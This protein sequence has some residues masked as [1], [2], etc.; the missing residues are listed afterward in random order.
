MKKK[1]EML[2]SDIWSAK[3]AYWILVLKVAIMFVFTIDGDRYYIWQ[4]VGLEQN[5]LKKNSNQATD[6]QTIVEFHCRL[7]DLNAVKPKM[8]LLR[9]SYIFRNFK[10]SIICHWQAYHFSFQLKSQKFH[11]LPHHSRVCR[12]PICFVDRGVVFSQ[13]LSAFHV[14][15]ILCFHI[16]WLKCVNVST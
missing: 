10:K 7:K 8:M 14:W 6:F 12:C 3:L 9:V 5:Y 1:V 2:N 11:R 15:S 13:N 4:F 16:S